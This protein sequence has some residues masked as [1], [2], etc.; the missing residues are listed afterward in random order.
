MWFPFWPIQR[1]LR[2]QPELRKRIVVLHT[3]LE[4]RA[5]RVVLANRRAL[6]Q[7][8]QPGMPLAEARSLVPRGEFREHDP[9]GDRET[10]RELAWRCQRFTPRAGLDQAEEPDSL[11]L[12]VMGCGHLFGDLRGLCL[13]VARDFR[14]MGYW[15]QGACAP[16]WGAAW[17]LARH[18][19]A[20]ALKHGRMTERVFEVVSAEELPARLAAL[21]VSALRLSAATL[22]MLA[23]CGLRTI[24]QLGE[25]PR[26][27]L[28][29][30]F[31]PQLLQMLDQATGA[32]DELLTP[33]VP[34]QPIISHLRWEYPI[35]DAASIETV[36]HQ[37]LERVLAELRS[38]QR[39]TQELRVTWKTETGDPE[40]LTIRLLTPTTAADR[41]AELLSLRQ[42][43]FPLVG[44][45]TSITMEAVPS[46]RN[47]TR[48]NTLFEQEDTGE[49]EFSHLIERLSQRLGEESVLRSRVQPEA[50][51]ELA[52]TSGPW[53]PA[54]RATEPRRSSHQPHRSKTPL[55]EEPSAAKRD[56]LSPPLPTRPLRL[57]CPPEC[58]TGAS[59]S[60]RPPER[61]RWRGHEYR[62]ADCSWPERIVTGWW[63]EQ[64]VQRDYYH[65]ETDNGARLWMF[66]DLKSGQWVVHGVYE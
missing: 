24:G 49:A 55:P 10:L 21:P 8:V 63:R 64:S 19:Q 22:L 18:P 51:P 43:R 36:L 14:H 61:F 26:S 4:S 34:P 42:E 30:R 15:V 16:T 45:V 54:G 62:V 7:G 50:Q 6:R 31:G 65:I 5:P 29:S 60:T 44:G 1:L 59:R 20:P 56:V 41:L 47:L 48:R 58:I 35:H 12:D 11:F 37:L 52:A 46:L 57:L 39:A 40:P 2:V 32:L 23:E 33:E 28:P 13:A 53:L 38:R 66:H 9:A 3:S 27:S 17:G 25:L